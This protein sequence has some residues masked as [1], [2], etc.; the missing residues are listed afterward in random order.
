MKP[1]QT[2]GPDGFLLVRITAPHFCAGLRL[3]RDGNACAPILQYMRDWS[4]SRIRN[5]CRDMEW[6]LEV[7]D[8]RGHDKLPPLDDCKEFPADA[9][10]EGK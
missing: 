6:K 10:R 4:L 8:L 7:V 2:R 3:C 5:Y 9:S 1:G